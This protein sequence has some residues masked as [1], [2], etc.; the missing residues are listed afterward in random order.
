MAIAHH[1]TSW[2]IGSNDEATQSGPGSGVTVMQS[3]T[4][5]ET[6]PRLA[7]NWARVI[8]GAE[9]WMVWGRPLN[10]RRAVGG[11]DY[12]LDGAYPHY[13][14]A[15]SYNYLCEESGFFEATEGQ[16]QWK[17]FFADDNLRLER[18]AIEEKQRFVSPSWPEPS[19]SLFRDYARDFPFLLAAWIMSGA[20]NPGDLTFAA[21]IAGSIETELLAVAT[22]LPLL[23]HESSL[24][25]E[26]AIYGLSEHLN[27]QVRSALTERLAV[28][29]SPGVR[30]AIE[31]ALE[32][33]L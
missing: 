16:P 19:E 33:G 24:V 12:S 11:C 15:P 30:G 9:V 8:P 21:E 31:E 26:G 22:L 27:E 7:G 1:E 28:E 10:T 13:S 3:S 20:L 18:R 23:E 25:R 32:E 5:L 2:P 4:P 17:L 29:E 14:A 6:T